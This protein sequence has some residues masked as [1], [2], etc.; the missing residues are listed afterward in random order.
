[1]G[2]LMGARGRAVKTW[3]SGEAVLGGTVAVGVVKG[4][5]SVTSSPSALNVGG[6]PADPLLP[7]R[8]S[9]LVLV[10]Q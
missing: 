7:Q 3:I 5:A 6:S 8:D 9:W 2:V 1:M 4:G 10:S